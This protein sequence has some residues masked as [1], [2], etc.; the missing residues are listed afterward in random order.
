MRPSEQIEEM[1][2]GSIRSIMGIETEDPRIFKPWEIAL[3]LRAARILSRDHAIHPSLRGMV[4]LGIVLDLRPAQLTPSRAE[5][6]RLLRVSVATIQRREAAWE[7]FD[8]SERFDLVRRASRMCLV[9][10]A[11][12]IHS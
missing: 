1:G 12:G 8:P 10:R 4:L 7:L 6:A 11:Q 5:L 3:C 2:S 9:W